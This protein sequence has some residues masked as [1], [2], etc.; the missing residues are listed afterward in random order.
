MLLPWIICIPVTT[1]IDTIFSFFLANDIEKMSN[2]EYANISLELILII[3]SILITI[4]FYGIFCVISQYFFYADKDN[5]R[6]GDDFPGDLKLSGLNVKGDKLR[7]KDMPEIRV[8]KKRMSQRVHL[9]LPGGTNSEPSAASD[10]IEEM[11]SYKTTM[12]FLDNSVEM[13]KND[14]KLS[15]G[16]GY[17]ADHD[18]FKTPVVLVLYEEDGSDMDR[19]TTV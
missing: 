5:G 1:V 8:T 19:G 4:N 16:H 13:A 18:E 7:V 12:T 17:G 10:S 9:E 11:G 2:R 14:P 3:D 6:H 15:E